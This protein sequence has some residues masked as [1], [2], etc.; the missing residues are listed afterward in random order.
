[1]LRPLFA[2]HLRVGLCGQGA[3]FAYDKESD[4]GYVARKEFAFALIGLLVCIFEL[5]AY[6][7]YQYQVRR[8]FALVDARMAVSS[9]VINLGSICD[10]STRGGRGHMGWSHGATTG[11]SSKPPV[12]ACLALAG[13]PEWVQF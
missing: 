3:G 7:R 9:S 13:Q 4:E 12:A 8:P 11:G 6:L 5:G 1:M 10:T 2:S